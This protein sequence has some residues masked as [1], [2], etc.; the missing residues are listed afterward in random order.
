[1]LESIDEIR[2]VFKGNFV[3]NLEKGGDLGSSIDNLWLHKRGQ[4]LVQSTPEL[5]NNS[6]PFFSF[7][8]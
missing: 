8:G 3:H 2:L 7:V 5:P 4:R 6:F 1:M